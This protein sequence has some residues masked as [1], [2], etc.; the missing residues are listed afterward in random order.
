[1]ISF[2]NVKKQDAFK[3]I[4]FRTTLHKRYFFLYSIFL[5]FFQICFT[6]ILHA[7]DVS[8]VSITVS[9]LE[10]SKAFYK[11]ILCFKE[12]KYFR[13]TNKEARI[14]FGIEDPTLTG[15]GVTLQ[16]EGN[17]IELMEFSSSSTGI[18]TPIDSKSNDLWFQHIAIVV[19]NMDSA[20]QILKSANVTHVSTAPQT[21]PDYI[22]AASG[23]KAFYFRDPDGHNL[24]LIFYPP[25][26]GNPKWQSQSKLFL[27]IDHTAIAVEETEMGLPFYTALGFRV[28][29]HSENYGTEQEH[30][31]QVFGARLLITGLQGKSGFGVEFLDYI[32]PPGGRAYPKTTKATDIIYWHTAIEVNNLD[33]TF[34]QLQ[35]Q[36]YDI[37]SKGIVEINAAN[38]EGVKSLLLRDTDGHFILL[39]QKKIN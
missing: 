11:N 20:Y 39:T 38:N 5:F 27:G 18:K 37:I 25:G 3:N 10:K 23:I 28:A 6:P 21:L 4:L 19:S 9:N 22:P 31:N 36:N 32:S 17:R 24:E 33:E 15:S 7:Q 16:L 29:G 8:H 26:K 13:I 12:I 34:T 35:N 30:L 14:L 1:M 2:P